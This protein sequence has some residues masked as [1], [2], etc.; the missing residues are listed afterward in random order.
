D[1]VHFFDVEVDYHKFDHLNA[2]NDLGFQNLQFSS[3]GNEIE[4]HSE[5]KYDLSILF[6]ES[7]QG[8]NSNFT[9][10]IYLFKKETIDAM[11]EEFKLILKEA[12]TAPGMKIGKIREDLLAKKSS[13]LDTQKDK[14]KIS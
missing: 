5:G 7:D 3:F 2:Y 1:R 8:I 11:A 4:N 9:Y 6:E 10:N 12:M 13:N 14:L